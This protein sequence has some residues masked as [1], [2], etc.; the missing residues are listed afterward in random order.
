M[1]DKPKHAP[2][3]WTAVERKS[4]L[5]GMAGSAR[6]GWCFV[7][8]RLAQAVVANGLPPPGWV[9]VQAVV[10][11]DGHGVTWDEYGIYCL[12][13]ELRAH[14]WPNGAYHALPFYATLDP[15]T[16][17]AAP[18]YV[19]D[20]V[21]RWDAAVRTLENARYE[22]LGGEVWRP[23]LGHNPIPEIDALRERIRT[24]ESVIDVLIK[25]QVETLEFNERVSAAHE[26][27]RRILGEKP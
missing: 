2:P 21:S 1:H 5:S 19:Q 14:Y 20:R 6:S 12:P 16:A 4:H 24:L 26:T 17:K 25:L 27:A 23:P 3:G 15:A 7:P 8:I 13:D 22:Y 11:A 10:P 9:F 18:G